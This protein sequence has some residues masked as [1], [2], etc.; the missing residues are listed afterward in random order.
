MP[1]RAPS[2]LQQAVAPGEAARERRR[3]RSRRARCGRAC[4]GDGTGMAAGRVRTSTVPIWMLVRGLVDVA[5]TTRSRGASTAARRLSS[6]RARS[7]VEGAGD[8][9]RWRQAAVP[10]RTGAADGIAGAARSGR[11]RNSAGLAAAAARRRPARR[12][13]AVQGGLAL[14]DAR[15]SR[16]AW[17][18]AAPLPAS[19]ARS[20]SERWIAGGQ[21]L[22]DAAQI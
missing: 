6:W 1:W 5:L 3:R 11:D 20:G 7:V 8:R 22:R 2:A 18:A 13:A 10:R 21:R 14:R 15:Q 12:G 17:P 16:A 9:L 19:G 4:G